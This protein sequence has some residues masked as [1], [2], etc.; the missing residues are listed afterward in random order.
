VA[1]EAYSEADT[2]RITSVAAAHDYVLSLGRACGAPPEL[3]P[4]TGFALSLP[5]V[6]KLPG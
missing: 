4:E 2:S 3:G 1:G 5:S 6:T